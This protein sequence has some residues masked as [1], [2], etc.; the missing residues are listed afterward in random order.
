MNTITFKVR[1]ENR[2][3]I[4]HDVLECLFSARIDL[5][6]M[7][8]KPHYIYL[9]I[10]ESDRWFLSDLFLA[11]QKIRGVKQV[12]IMNY[13]PS[14]AR[15]N[16]MNTIL[17]TVSEGIVLLDEQL[18][19]QAINR[20]AEEMLH[21]TGEEASGKPFYRLWKQGTEEAER[22]LR[23]GVEI[24]NVSVSIPVAR[25]GRA[26]FVVSYLPVRPTGRRERQGIVVVLRDMKQIQQ[27]IQ[28]VNETE[29]IT[30]DDIIH[31]SAAMRN[32]METAKRIAGKNATIIL[33]GESGT[34]KELFARAI[35]FASSRANGPFV[36]INCAA[37][38]ETLLESELFGYEA[39]TFTGGLKD[40]KKGLIETAQGGT[41]F[42]DEIGEIPLHLQAKLLRVFEDRT[43]RRVGSHAVTRLDVRIIAATNRDLSAM[44]T[45]GEFREDLFYRLNVIPIHIPPLRERKSDIRL[46][47]EFFLKKVCRLVHR[48]PLPLSPQAI[49]LLESYHWPGNV[50]ELQNVI[51]RAVY[52]CPEEQK[53]ITEIYLKKELRSI[54]ADRRPQQCLKE[55]MES[56]EKTIL[57]DALHKYKSARQAA[58]HLGLSH[59]A[60]L[61]KI[62]KYQ[63]GV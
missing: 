9:K 46:L 26:R 28:S 32:C 24:Q 59:T 41:L 33:Q 42:L 14:E 37:I 40:G 7:E 51:E 23:E 2:V 44:M 48:N 25:K 53:E 36:P 20:A 60:L 11:I 31:Q 6:S 62:K 15:E 49:R 55:Q 22:C 50:R 17:S 5:I 21:I 52:L 63:L 27:L 38:P 16:Q 13:L 4:T 3:G 56:Y 1:T 29:V 57:A 10:P 47:A 18:C 54:P 19:I 35:H 61:N 34:G 12:E 58:K 39:G 30:F 8:V 43:I 45:K